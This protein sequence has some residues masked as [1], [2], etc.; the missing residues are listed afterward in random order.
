M[1][2]GRDSLA[3][4]YDKYRARTAHLSIV[5]IPS[6]ADARV[7]RS[8]ARDLPVI[9]HL[10]NVSPGDP[11]GPNWDNLASQDAI[12]REL[13]AVW[14]NEDIGVWNIGPY[15]I[16]YFTPPLLEPEVADL[17]AQRIAAMRPRL[18]VPFLAEIP[19]CSMVAGR[20]SLGQFFERVVRDGGCDLVLDLAHVYSYA[21]AKGE[22]ALRVL[23]S[24]PLDA[25]RHIHVAGGFVDP[26]HSWCYV[27]SHDHPIVPPVLDLLRRSVRACDR[28]EAITFEVGPKLAEGVLDSE[29]D[30]VEGLLDEEGHVPRLLPPAARG[31]A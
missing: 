14:C 25:V 10:N 15:Y 11:D 6:L 17:I 22:S 28:L 9:H 3:R 4:F 2:S 1:D 16:P 12:S 7:F 23:E 29:L 5:G 30:R 24:M 20:L 31:A 13:G 21:L 8:F 18:S 26:E 27:D 19:S